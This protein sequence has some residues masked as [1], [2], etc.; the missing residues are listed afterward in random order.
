[1]YYV[2]RGDIKAIT[3]NKDQPKDT[4]SISFASDW[5]ESEFITMPRLKKETFDGNRV[6]VY[7]A[8]ESFEEAK[9]TAIKYLETLKA[10]HEARVS[11]H[12]K[13]AAKAIKK[14]EELKSK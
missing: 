8:T 9:S 4:K 5:D 13:S 1:M 10:H 7:S 2:S 12:Q 6:A 14:L 11:Q 3:L